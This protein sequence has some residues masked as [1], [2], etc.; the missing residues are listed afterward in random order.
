MYRYI[1]SKSLNREKV[2]ELYKDSNWVSYTENYGELNRAFKNSLAI[3][4]AWDKDRLIGMVRAVGDGVF[5]LYVQDLIVLSGYRNKG[6]GKELLRRI[7]MKYFGCRKKIIVCDKED[8]IYKYYIKNG[9]CDIDEFNM[10][11][12]IKK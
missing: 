8:R 11:C 9:F 3:I 4:S 7:T 5:I 2:I 10:K 12:M 1:S 6:I